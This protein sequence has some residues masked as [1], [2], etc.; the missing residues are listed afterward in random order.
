[1]KLQINYKYIP[2]SIN[3][4]TRKEDIKLPK[5]FCLL[6]CSHVSLSHRLSFLLFHVFKTHFA[7]PHFPMRKEPSLKVLQYIEHFSEGDKHTA[8][9]GDLTQKSANE[10]P[11]H[12]C[13][14]AIQKKQ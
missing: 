10:N 7:S 4:S 9:I 13:C 12:E 1:M 3:G 8:R 11:S 2:Y 6:N 5:V 14:D